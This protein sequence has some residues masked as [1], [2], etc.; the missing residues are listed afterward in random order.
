[1]PINQWT[2]REMSLAFYEHEWG[3]R[4]EAIECMVDIILEV[5]EGVSYVKVLETRKQP[6][7]A[8][9]KQKERKVGFTD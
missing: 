6:R 2:E 3:N 5:L 8:N 1:M 4:Q 9:K 7:E